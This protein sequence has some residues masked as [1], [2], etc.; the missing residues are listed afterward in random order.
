MSARY[1]A[2]AEALLLA[3]GRWCVMR[4]CLEPDRRPLSD[5]TMKVNEALSAL[6]RASAARE[7]ERTPERPLDDCEPAEWLRRAERAEAEL[8]R[9]RSAFGLDDALGAGASP[10]GRD[11]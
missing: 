7:P 5:H 8:A 1:T 2:E 9:L 3:L 6:E 11:G 4:D 10:P